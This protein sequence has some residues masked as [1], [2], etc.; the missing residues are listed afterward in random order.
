MFGFG[1][2]QGSAH[3]SQSGPGGGPERSLGAWSKQVKQVYLP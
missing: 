3:Q 1:R 2:G